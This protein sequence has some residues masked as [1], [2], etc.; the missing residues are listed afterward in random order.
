MFKVEIL[1]NDEWV[2]L[3]THTQEIDAQEQLNRFINELGI[4]L[5]LLRI[6]SI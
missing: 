4:S 6:I 3:S 2:V 5:E 1:K